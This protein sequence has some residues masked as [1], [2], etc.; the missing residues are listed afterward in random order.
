M[1]GTARHVVADGVGSVCELTWGHPSGESLRACSVSLTQRE[2]P[3]ASS[4]F[5]HVCRG[6][7]A[8][9]RKISCE[10]SE[11]SEKSEES[12]ESEE[13]IRE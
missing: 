12:E 5:G 8:K 1:D 2:S 13:Y 3:R 10:K 6:G 11:K 7:R 9:E 4:L